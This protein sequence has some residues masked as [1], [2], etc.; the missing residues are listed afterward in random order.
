M[1]TVTH[2]PHP[3]RLGM[4]AWYASEGGRKCQHCGKYR[5]ESDLFEEVHRGPGII[6]DFAPMCRFCREKGGD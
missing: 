5:K 1:L 2:D 6:I 3:R 4:M